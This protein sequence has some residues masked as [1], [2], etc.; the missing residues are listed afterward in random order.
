MKLRVAVITTSLLVAL[1]S[2]AFALVSAPGPAIVA[3]KGVL[4]FRNLADADI[5][6]YLLST[7]L[8][9]ARSKNDALQIDLAN[10]NADFQKPLERAKAIKSIPGGTQLRVLDLARTVD[11][12]NICHVL[13][14]D[15]T[16]WWVDCAYLAPSGN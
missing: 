13:L 4:A 12:L 6:Q 8:L 14:A 2:Q 11:D 7:Q 5:F 9:A 1:A 16:A 10:A 3:G 15:E